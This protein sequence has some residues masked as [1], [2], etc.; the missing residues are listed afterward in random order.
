MGTRL[1]HQQ[2]FDWA[3]FLVGCIA[4]ALAGGLAIWAFSKDCLSDHQSLILLWAF[5]IA[6]GFAAGSFTGSLKLS[7]PINGLSVGAV[8]GFAVWLLTFVF[9]LPS[10][11]SGDTC[12]R[13]KVT[14]FDFLVESHHAKNGVNVVLTKLERR[15][16]RDFDISN[17]SDL[18]I[19]F[20]LVIEGFEIKDARKTKIRINAAILNEDGK[21]LAS[22]DVETLDSISE[23]KSLPNIISVGEEAVYNLTGLSSEDVRRGQYMP[24]VILLEDFSKSEIP[25]K[26]GSIRVTIADE[27]SGETVVYEERIDV[28][29]K[30]NQ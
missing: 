20:G 27:L 1:Q 24:I 16:N 6:S 10:G 12:Q 21:V 13:L 17:P 15:S 5:P 19:A 7:G 4:L 26:H 22:D 11:T 28:N 25:K 29:W 9:W 30:P 23:W 8:G 14:K 18:Q 3:L 2:Q